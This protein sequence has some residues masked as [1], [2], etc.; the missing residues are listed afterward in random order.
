M[1]FGGTRALGEVGLAM[2][3]ASAAKGAQGL[4]LVTNTE[5]TLI[6]AESAGARFG[7]STTASYRKTFLVA[8]P[9]LEG[10]VIV[11]HAVPQTILNQYP[12]LISRSEMHSL[13]NLR[14]IPKELNSTLHNSQINTEWNRFLKPFEASGASPT[15]SQ[16]LQKATEIDAKYGSQFNPPVGGR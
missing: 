15:R 6:A 10:Q 14:G 11:H 7:S 2:V 8:N 13:E 9:E 4:R 12:G 16:L 5:R 1:F 3:G